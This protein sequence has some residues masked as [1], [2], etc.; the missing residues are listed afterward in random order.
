MAATGAVAAATA[1]T[2]SFEAGGAGAPALCLA[3]GSTARAAL[4]T[5]AGV[6]F[7]QVTPAV[8]EAAIKHAARAAGATPVAAALRLASAKARAVAAPGL[9]LGADQLLVCD[10]AWF[11]KPPTLAAAATQLATLRGRGHTLPTAAVLMRDG[12]TVWQHVAEPRL[13]MRPFSAAFIDAYLLAEGEAVLTS[14]GA[15]RIEGRGIQLFDRIEGEHA[16]I[17]GLPLLALLG[18]LRENG[19]LVQ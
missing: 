19:V 11:D 17:L 18:F 2:A 7:R 14:V 10:G 3:S 16:A 1:T 15:Y 5:G 13:V 12:A 4:L 8:D 9:V 6:P